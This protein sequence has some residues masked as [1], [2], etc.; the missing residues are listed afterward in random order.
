M[1]GIAGKITFSGPVDRQ[2]IERMCSVL[3]HRGPDSR[4]LH[5]AD[6]VGLGIQRLAI[7]DVVG[8]DQPIYSEDRTLAVVMNGEI[9]NFVEL[10]EELIARG[11]QFSSRSDTEV[12]VHLYEEHGEGFV[13]RLRGMFAIA[14]WDSRERKLVLARDRVG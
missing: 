7:I 6:G 9:Y 2:L 13:N 1:C 3:E 12:V 11:H 5:I 8:G 10:R 4:G 14:L